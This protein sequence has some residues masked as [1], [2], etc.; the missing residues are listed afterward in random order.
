MHISRAIAEH[1]SAPFPVHEHLVDQLLT[2]HNA[3]TGLR[4]ERNPTVAH[5]L[6]V[7]AG[8][9]YADA[10]T[11]ATMMARTGLDAN[12]CVQLTQVVDAMYIY[13]TA[14]LVQSRCGRVVILSYR[15]TELASIGNWLGNL[16]SGRESLRLLTAGGVETPRVHAGF[17]RN[18]RA[19]RWAVDQELKTALQARSLAD[20]DLRLEYPMQVLFVTGHSLGAAMA[21]LFALSLAERGANSTLD[22][23]LRAIYTFGGPMSIGNPLP[24]TNAARVG[25][26]LYRHVMP[27]DPVPALPPVAWGQFAH[28]GQEYR[29]TDGQWRRSETAVA[30]LSRV[31]EIPKSLLAMVANEK[32]L[33]TLRYRSFAHGPHNYLAALRPTGRVTEFGDYAEGSS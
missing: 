16:D 21:E 6:G 13:S 30:Q 12:A 2:A 4:A 18:F 24:V 20:P 32:R 15:G 17:Y 19:T 31:R 10:E 8:Y 23:H 7:C 22:S 14:S 1:T 28:I 27:D 25:A 5:V 3:S 33:A 11:L 26:R 29:Y 9:T